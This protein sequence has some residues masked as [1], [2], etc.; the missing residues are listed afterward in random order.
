MRLSCMEGIA[1]FTEA[2]CL[3]NIV[4]E[5]IGLE[6]HTIDIFPVGGSLDDTTRITLAQLVVVLC[7]VR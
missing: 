2:L 4:Q 5:Q 7:L 3:V 1:F 6:D